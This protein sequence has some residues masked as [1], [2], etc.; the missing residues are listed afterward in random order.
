MMSA[1]ATAV[2]IG[3]ENLRNPYVCKEI[4]EQL[5][6]L[7]DRLNIASLSEIIGRAHQ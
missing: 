7:L 5:P 4:I 3:A 6:S 2:Q 1:G